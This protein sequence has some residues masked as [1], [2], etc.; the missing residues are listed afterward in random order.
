MDELIAFAQETRE[1]PWAR[2]IVV[3]LASVMAAKIVDVLICRS[4]LRLS[5]RSET[6][7]DDRLIQLLHRPI[8]ITVVLIGLNIAIE[9][10]EW[11]PAVEGVLIAL[12]RTLAILIWAGAGF[13]LASTTLDGLSRLADRV[14][15]LEARTLPLFDNL[16][17]IVVFALAVYGVLV[18]WDLNL[19][20]WLASAGVVG[21]A[22]GFA[23]KDS[24]A[25]LFGGLFV[26]MDAP[27]KIGDYINLDSGER[28]QVVKIGLRSTRLLTRD[29]VEITLP[30]AHIANSKVINETGGPT[31]RPE[32]R[33]TWVWPTAPTSIECARYC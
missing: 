6:D 20:P 31:R 19:T 23:A 9:T 2:A 11:S 1:I 32:W 8:F 3:V 14:T 16:S 5:L 13:K 26:I 15:W 18:V 30:N 7:L 33:S 28:G 24:L 29:D 12:I 27:Y 10:L 4:L 17:K 22:V 25:N 21:I